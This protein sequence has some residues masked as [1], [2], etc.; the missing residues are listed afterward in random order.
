MKVIDKHLKG[1][2]VGGGSPALGAGG[3]AAG[4]GAVVSSAA[5]SSVHSY[6]IP[7]NR[8]AFIPNS[9]HAR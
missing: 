2:T 6:Y 3:G 7:G 1:L 8:V 5:S 9:E 4:L